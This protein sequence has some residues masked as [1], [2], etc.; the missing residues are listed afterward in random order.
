MSGPHAEGI[1]QVTLTEVS[2]VK[3]SEPG[4]AA[5]RSGLDTAVRVMPYAAIWIVL[6]VPTLRTMARGWRPVGDDASIA[7]QAWNTFSLHAP[8]VGQGTG[9]ASGAGGV[10][11]TGDP[12][13]LGF[14][15]LAPFV[16][17]D[18][19]QGALMGAALLCG[20]A[21]S[22]G[23]YVLQK[24]A[25]P[26][27]AVVFALVVADLAIVSPFPFVDP[28]WN[29]SFA[30]FWFLSFLAVAFAVGLGNLRYLPLLVFIG[31]VTI[32]SHLLFLPSAA[33]TLI[34]AVVCGLLLKRPGGYRWLWWT[35]GVAA[36]CWVAPLG[37][38]LFGSHPNGTA[39][40]HSVG[41]GSGQPIKTVS[42]MLGLHALARAAS[43][44]AVWASP[45]PL[46]PLDSYSDVLHNGTLVFCWLFA[47]LVAVLVLAARHKKTYL[48][49]LSAVTI[50]SA[51]GLV[52]LYARVPADYQLSFGWI[53][54]AVW[55]VG[56]CIWVTLGFAVVTWARSRFPVR[57][58]FRV[59]Q[60][61]VKTCVLVLM[62]IATFG[63]TAV[64]M[65][66]YGGNGQR[67][68]FAAMRRVQT[69]AAIV[70]KEV[71]RGEV[72]IA[73]SY[74]GLNF[75]QGIQYEHGTA[76]LLRTAGWIP[77]LPVGAD[78][79]LD[80]P[81]HSDKPFVVFNEHVTSQ[82]GFRRYDHYSTTELNPPKNLNNTEKL[83]NLKK[84]KSLSP[85]DLEKLKSLSQKNLDKL[86][87]LSPGDLQKLKSLSPTQLEKLKNL[88]KVGALPG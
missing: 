86:K 22:L 75:L 78:G 14:W 63:A 24:S 42:S 39:L 15:L 74:S 5:S 81:I 50:A 46:Q 49:S 40:L 37:Q 87:H 18:P 7:L 29:S 10:Q 79:L 51:I 84:L 34:A 23:L 9:A 66:P 25:G 80:Y 53:S 85:K 65:F 12:G 4:V 88:K 47:A 72:G 71:P 21:L 48:L 8:L 68:D 56:I 32:D 70:E 44:K 52:V 57:Q 16:H 64:V 77:G 27:A 55:I 3:P 19:G 73:D 43:P 83:K 31:S 60:S 30:F 13:P 76:Y 38:Q 1:V 17:I 36:V 6:L 28:L 41:L 45:R 2:E 20:A 11:T 67:L 82:T 35:I 58:G 59:S 54:L 62:A 26:W 69:E 61:A 33:L